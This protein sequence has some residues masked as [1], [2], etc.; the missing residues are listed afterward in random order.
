MRSCTAP[1]PIDE[2]TAYWLGE[3]ETAQAERLE[4]HVF[5]CAHCAGRLEWLAA[6]SDGVRS[7]VR[8]GRVGLFVSKQFVQ[9][10]VQAG[11]RFREYHLEL[12]GS[13]NCTIRADDDGVLSHIR[14]PLAGAKRV[15]VVRRVNVGGEQLEDRVP[16]VPFDPAAGE[17]LFIPAAAA[18]K[19]MPSHV[20]EVTLL[21][22]D[23]AGERPIGEYTFRHTAGDGPRE[24]GAGA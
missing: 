2:L 10:L 15:D 14:A 12:N 9:A 3:L 22:V 18:L 24:S 17:V 13:V 1:I 5:A 8:A 7:A 11:L 23:E 20:L 16:D 6:L 19:A 4:E 21:A